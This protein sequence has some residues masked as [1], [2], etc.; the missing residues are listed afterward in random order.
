MLDQ[1]VDVM[2][3]AQ[4]LTIN[5]DTVKRL[6]R[7]GKLPATRWGNKYIIDKD[8]LEMFAS[9]YNPLPGRKRR[10]L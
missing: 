7:Q 4:R 6:I 10:L 3:A 5:V 1:Y 8:H 9:T 2:E